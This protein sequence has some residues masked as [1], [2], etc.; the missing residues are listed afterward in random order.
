[1]RKSEA[2][3][4]L[5]QLEDQYEGELNICVANLDDLGFDVP[6]NEHPY[7]V[8]GVETGEEEEEEDED[9]TSLQKIIRERYEVIAW[10]SSSRGWRVE[11]V[12]SWQIQQES[13]PSGSLYI[14]DT[15]NRKFVPAN[16]FYL[17]PRSS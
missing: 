16:R 8:V 3:H 9:A 13:K 12:K 6:K 7:F 4:L 1:M 10:D 17:P 5:E 11:K 15:R 14:Y 2:E